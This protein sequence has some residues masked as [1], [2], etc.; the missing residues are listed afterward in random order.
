MAAEGCGPP[1]HPVCGGMTENAPMNVYSVVNPIQY[2]T[3]PSP[4][5]PTS[6]NFSP[7]QWLAR[8]VSEA[9]PV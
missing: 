2:A 1:G 9:T 8:I 6:P 3:H 4:E 5:G 7:W